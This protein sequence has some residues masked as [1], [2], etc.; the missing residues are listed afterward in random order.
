MADALAHYQKALAI[1]NEMGHQSSAAQ[2]LEA[3]GL[4]LADQ[5]DLQGAS[6][7][8]QQA[9]ATQR[10]IGEKVNYADTERDMGRVL[11]QQDN[12]QQARKLFDEALS[13]QQQLGEMESSAETRLALAELDCDSGRPS[14]AEQ[15]ARAAL[16]VFQAQN[17]TDSAIFAAAVLSRSLLLEGK[18]E[19]AAA[20]LEAPL[21]LAK[22]SSDVTTQLSLDLA[23]ANVLAASNQLAVAERTAQRV[24]AE[25]PK[26]L[27]RVRLEASL[28]LAEI[29]MKGKDATGGRARLQEVSR[30]AHEKG[31]ELIARQAADILPSEH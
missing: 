19:E 25:A 7:M 2:A 21:K 27:F 30:T 9:L 6:K 5:G 8:F 1:S 24:L 16:Q 3:I 29:Q 13:T 22:K 4:A 20:S 31:F 12:L 14:E 26:D 15:L 18:V 11:M 23:H 10:D 28:T 17:E